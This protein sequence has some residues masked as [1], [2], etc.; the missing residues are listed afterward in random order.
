MVLVGLTLQPEDAYCDL[1]DAVLREDADYVEVAPETLWRLDADGELVANGFHERFARF[2][3]ETDKPFV[4]HGV[5]ASLGSV[6][7]ADE[8]RLQRWLKRITADCAVFDYRWYTDHLGATTMAGQA[9]TL[10]MPLLMDTTM[11]EVVRERLLQIQ[12]V[13][14]HVGFE[15]S[16]FY[17]L[18]GPWLDEP[19]FFRAIL[20][21]P[22]THLLLDLH[23]VYT[24][25][26]N[27]GH[28]PQRYIGLLDLSSVIE[29]HVS[30]GTMSDPAWHPDGKTMRLDSHDSEIPEA[31]WKLL[32]GVAPRCPNLAGVM[33]ER[34]EGTV[35]QSDVTTIRDELARARRLVHG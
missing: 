18:L 22:K 28:D 23:N 16:V 15:N 29:I 24:M 13:V 19:D 7:P 9:M 31:V 32:E 30:G 3:Q 35:A 26:V 14:P 1:L 17:F 33:V 34:L 12:R 2:K 21:A 25:A 20:T 4:A 27:T 5:G 8:P 10:P 6:D 11:A